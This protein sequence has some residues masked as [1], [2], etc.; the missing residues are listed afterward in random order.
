MED[1]KMQIFNLK[2]IAFL[3]VFLLSLPLSAKESCYSVVLDKGYSLEAAK[4]F[5]RYINTE[6]KGMCFESALEKGWD[7]YSAVLCRH[8][9]SDDSGACA[10][11]AIKKG[12]TVKNAVRVCNYGF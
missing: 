5:C 8:I 9:K 6:A 7:I 4:T 3:S 12:Y 2:R 10:A 11:A 1:R